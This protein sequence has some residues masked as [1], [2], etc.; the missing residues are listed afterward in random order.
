MTNC[1]S[2][3]TAKPGNLARAALLL[4]FSSAPA[5]ACFDCRKAVETQVYGP[6]FTLNL[7][8]LLLPLGILAMLGAA[9]CYWDTLVGKFRKQN[10]NKN[11][12]TNQ[13]KAQNKDQQDEQ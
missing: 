1:L 3:I 7:L 10:L 4:A 6:D 13:N 2:A 8:A 11:Q 9:A 5:W 12:S